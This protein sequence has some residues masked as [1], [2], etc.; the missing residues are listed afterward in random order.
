MPIRRN[1]IAALILGTALSCL[2]GGYDAPP[3]PAEAVGN[4]SRNQ[5]AEAGPALKPY[6]AVYHIEKGMLSTDAKRRLARQGDDRWR[7]SQEASVLFVSVKEIAHLELRDGRLRPLLYSYEQRP[8]QRRDERTTFDWENRRA[9][10]EV[11]REK[12]RHTTIEPGTF[13]QLSF[14]LKMR[15]DLLR[16][17][18]EDGRVYTVVD[19]GR[20]KQYRVERIGEEMLD[21]SLG[22]LR[23]VK[24]RQVRIGKED[25]R[26]TLVWVAPE[27]NYLLVRLIRYEDGDEYRLD[28]K[29]ATVGGEKV[30]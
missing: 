10:T 20:L 29:S 23:T 19:R 16:G 18:F 6:D 5:P 7:L 27:W 25:E 13:D 9:T 24:L 11:Y 30:R 14:Q 3:R 1:S 12:D 4:D 8:Q 21:T 17:E 26:E 15:L 22:T 2:A 28:L